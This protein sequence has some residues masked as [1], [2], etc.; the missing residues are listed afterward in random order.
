M[1][2]TGSGR[3]PWREIIAFVIAS[4]VAVTAPGQENANKSDPVPLAK[5]PLYISAVEAMG[6]SLPGVAIEKL[7]RLLGAGK[8][9]AAETGEIKLKLLEAY[10]RQ[11]LADEAVAMSA[12]KELPAASDTVFW[13]AEALALAGRYS[14]AEK[15]FAAAAAEPA[16][17]YRVEALF[18]RSNLLV[19]L[20]DHAT[21]IACLAPLFDGKDGAVAAAARVRAAEIFFLTG[22]FSKARE[23]LARIDGAP[24]GLRTRA[25][26]LRG[27]MFL[28]EKRWGDAEKILAPL[29]ND[30]EGQD[31]R[32]HYACFLAL[33]DAYAGNGEA[34]KSERVLKAFLEKYPGNPLIE[35]AFR[36]LDALGVFSR[37][38]IDPD[39]I[40]WTES[41][42]PELKAVAAY[43]L[44]VSLARAE[45]TDDALQV[46]EEFVESH[47][48]QFLATE[49][50]LQLAELYLKKD[51][52]QNA[53]ASLERV[54]ENTTVPEVLAHVAFLEARTRFA[55][56]EFE[57]A[58]ADFTKIQLQSAAP[59]PDDETVAA[60]SFNA[61]LAAL[62]LGDDALFES[63]AEFLGRTSREKMRSGLLLQWALFAA[64]QS[65]ARA[66]A[67][68]LDFAKR[69]PGHP[70]LG[71]VHIALAEIDFLGFPPK[72][73][74]ARQH[75][76]RALAAPLSP[77]QAEQV[78]YIA[79]WVADSAGESG[80]AAA[81][82]KKF[83]E[84]WPGSPRVPEMR[85]KLGEIFLRDNDYPNAVTQFELLVDEFPQ[86]SF[87]ETALFFAGRAARL[88]MNP[89]SIDK[90]I[91][92]WGRVV[93]MDG[94][95]A[96][97]AREQQALAKMD[98]G[99]EA[100]A[101]TVF[102]SILENEPPPDGDLYFSVLCSKGQ[103]LFIISSKRDEALGEAIAVF[104]S[105][106]A[107]E[108][109]SPF[110]RNQASVRKAKCLEKR[111]ESGKALEVYYDVI[112]DGTP[113]EGNEPPEYLW[114]YRAGFEA[115]RLLEM[116]KDYKGAIAVADKISRSGGSR[117][118]E[119]AQIANRLRLQ[120]F[121]WER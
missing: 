15:L 81:L 95:L 94:D 71:R 56:G 112:R 46:L 99:N 78:D 103:A 107:H 30:P 84:R 55:A 62:R 6:D 37:T 105:V 63:N 66:A 83:I 120:N 89:N 90:A 91:E 74:S 44:G 118:Q 80:N 70:E 111:N 58:A 52:W 100:E 60:A 73:L 85:M 19:L 35:L 23:E 48:D 61:A 121:V 75:L 68:L 86:S 10:V 54:R 93:D 67:R 119:A 17:R 39:L 87:A 47:P 26:C 59:V 96:L 115:I 20:G 65:D 116:A 41:P 42:Q 38:P 3:R 113:S 102:D 32:L 25:A 79:V 64:S 77:E 51:D 110:W 18:S 5:D 49:A 13:R 1:H 40:I 106:I 29:V 98:L 14:D 50:L 53:F 117:D 9:A 31:P 92:I 22:S 72:P 7:T 34:N 36:R 43:Y 24:P 2:S 45:E 88:T 108:N 12:A 57:S 82:G 104:E 114:F 76:D 28:A 109:A 16:A 21:A 8:R 101:L 27:R 33:S 4:A 11:G 97:S 69:F